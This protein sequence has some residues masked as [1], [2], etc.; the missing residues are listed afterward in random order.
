MMG[1]K[2]TLGP[3]ASVLAVVTCAAELAA[4]V[5]L[6]HFRWTEDFEGGDPVELTHATGQRMVHFE[7][8]TTEHAPAGTRCYKLDV[9]FPGDGGGGHWGIPLQVPL[10]GQLTLQAKIL[11]ESAPPEPA[12][13]PG[14]EAHVRILPA[15]SVMGEPVSYPARET[16]GTWQDIE[17][18]LVGLTRGHGAFLAVERGLWAAHRRHVGFELL[19]VFLRIRG[20]KG[21]R[22]VVYLD[23]IVVEGRVPDRRQYA[24]AIRERWAPVRQRVE[25]V[26]RRW[27]DTMSGAG[28]WRAHADDHASPAFDRLQTALTPIFDSAAARIERIAERGHLKAAGYWSLEYDVRTIRHA[29]ANLESLATGYRG[30]IDGAAC[31]VVAPVSGIMI[32]PDTHPLPGRLADTIELSATPGEY[33]PFSMVL[34][35]QRRL[36]GVS[37]EV[38]DLHRDS[39]VIPSG[40]VD[41]KW[42]KCWYQSEGAWVHYGRR[43]RGKVLVPELLLNDPTLVR[44]DHEKKNNHLK[45]RFAEGDRYQWIDDPSPVYESVGEG[46]A[47][48][49]PAARDFPVRD[50][51]TVQPIDIP[52]GFNQQVWFTVHVPEDAEPGVY[53]GPVQVFAA[54]RPLGTLPLRLRVLPLRL[55]DPRTYYD[56]ERTFTSSI[57]CEANLAPRGI[58]AISSYALNEQ[59]YRATMRNLAAHGVTN[60]VMSQNRK[61]DMIISNHFPPDAKPRPR[62]DDPQLR[63]QLLRRAVQIRREAG[64][65]SE[66]VYFEGLVT[67]N[68]QQQTQIENLRQQV[69]DF[70]AKFESMGI[71][72]LHVYGIDEAH[73]ERLRSQRAA[74]QAVHE[75]GAKVF[76]AGGPG[77]FE[78]MGDL[79]DVMVWSGVPDREEAVRWHGAGGRVFDYAN[80]Q[81]GVE[82]PEVNR[83]NFGFVLWRANYDGAMTWAFQSSY[84]QGIWNDFNCNRRACAFAMPT[85]DRPID[86]IAWEGYREGIDDIR[87]GSTLLLAIH[88]ARHDGDAAKVRVADEARRYLESFSPYA[89]LDEVRAKIVEYTLSLSQ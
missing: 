39:S 54:G 14:M 82:D 12:P 3:V 22:V 77:N 73:G 20:S 5:P 46:A 61:L 38:G 72:D 7:G 81:V 49:A 89:D 9:S 85:M 8:T 59:Q 23:D 33:E 16:F 30:P 1:S 24:A 36:E 27:R 80:P 37:I 51:D 66:S 10:E 84:T 44:V 41:V 67:G 87:Y 25:D 86:T 70:K 15:G 17:I 4:D 52:A 48:Y 75:A 74:W 63:E 56:P 45:L 88:R 32:L 2:I 34:R 11:V 71:T 50:G 40:A 18:D 6:E 19:N 26:V 21:G 31:V 62:A 68:P 83:R 60:P 47:Y 57:Y 35:A 28:S 13:Q 79:L 42:V 53:E 58:H 65:T 69:R 76:V 64:M 55:A 29:A 43:G 78:A